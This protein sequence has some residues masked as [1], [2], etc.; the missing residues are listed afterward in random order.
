MNVSYIGAVG[1]HLKDHNKVPSCWHDELALKQGDC[2]M[3]VNENALAT[4]SRQPIRSMI[5]LRQI[6]GEAFSRLRGVHPYFCADF[7]R[8]RSSGFIMLIFHPSLHELNGRLNYSLRFFE[9]L[10]DAGM[11]Y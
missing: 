5:V 10:H 2:L 3:F 7:E 4:V 1:T 8:N 6:L 9:V 11:M